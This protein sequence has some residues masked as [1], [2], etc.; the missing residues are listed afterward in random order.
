MAHFWL[1][2]LVSKAP[3]IFGADRFKCIPVTELALF[4]QA[5][6]AVHPWLL[7]LFKANLLLNDDLDDSCGNDSDEHTLSLAKAEDIVF[8][9]KP[10]ELSHCADNFLERLLKIEQIRLG[11]EEAGAVNKELWT[12]SQQ[13]WL[14]QMSKWLAADM[15]VIIIREE[16]Y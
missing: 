5:L 16:E 9:G 11:L 10:Y 4:R 3:L 7:P 14:E 2:P 6:D 1:T 15:E 8:D 13:L 12:T